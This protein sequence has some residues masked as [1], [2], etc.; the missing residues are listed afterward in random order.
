MSLN[1][2][3]NARM[4]ETYDEAREAVTREIAPL[5][6]DTRGTL[7]VAPSGFEDRLGYFVPWG[8]REWMVD[9]DENFIL[10]NNAAT[11]VDKVTGFVEITTLSTVLDRVDAMSPISA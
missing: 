5:W 3:Y 2:P 7:Y 6:G 1:L 10:L 8:A 11:F 9:G 4:I